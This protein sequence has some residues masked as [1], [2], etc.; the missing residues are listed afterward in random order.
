MLDEEAL[1]REKRTRSLGA[2][3][4]L[5]GIIVG[6]CP[7]TP[8]PDG[9]KIIRTA[10]EQGVTLFDTTEAYGPFANEEPVGEAVAPFRDRVVIATKVSF[11]IDCLNVGDSK[12]DPVLPWQPMVPV[13]SWTG[14]FIPVVKF[15][16]LR[17]MGF[18]TPL[19]R[20]SIRRF[21]LPQ[22]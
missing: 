20:N 7:L 10:F 2:G 14:M 16:S 4:R 5:H 15:Y 8:R 19:P 22:Y 17:R 6:L 18:V 1:T 11:D 21:R 9:V 3:I 13:R 12:F